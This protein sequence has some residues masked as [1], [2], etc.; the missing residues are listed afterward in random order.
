MPAAAVTR[1][2]S[3]LLLFRGAAVI[4]GGLVG[5]ALL[6]H[7]RMLGSPSL[8]VFLVSGLFRV[9]FVFPMLFLMREERPVAAISYP[10]LA[11]K[12]LTVP[13]R[14]ARRRVR[15][16]WAGMRRVSIRRRGGK[17]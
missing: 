12:L 8:G 11:L 7:V 5:G 14:A 3:F 2:T 1:Q 9:A 10:G 16:G 6:P 4:G 17:R 15:S 13:L